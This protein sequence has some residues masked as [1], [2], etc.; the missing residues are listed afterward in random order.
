MSMTTT[1][2]VT[3]RYAEDVESGQAL[4]SL[5]RRPTHVQVFR[6]SA[7]T[8]NSHRIHFD[9]EYAATEGYPDVLVQ[10][11]LHG[12]FLTSLVDNFAGEAGEM[13]R[14]YYTV[15]RFA[16]PGDVLT[17]E[18]EVTGIED[19]DGGRVCSLEIREVRGSDE[20]VCA[21]GNAEVFLP[22]RP[23]TQGV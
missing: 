22:N 15:R 20:V 3:Q 16:V 11:H 17:L 7:M 14:V 10:S 1:T 18:G 6:Y 2:E 9:K 13:R 4:P 8:W 19:V 21:Q 5:E 23:T 12:A